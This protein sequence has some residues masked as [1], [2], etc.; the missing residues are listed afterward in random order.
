MA[1]P[2][3]DPGNRAERLR[4]HAEELQ[5]SAS[6]LGDAARALVDEL[7]SAAREQL[8][9]RPFTTLGATAAVGLVLG[10]GLS[11]GVLRRLVGMGGRV[12]VG[13]ALRNVVA[14]GSGKE[15]GG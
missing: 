5:S 8:E 12:A 10:G 7:S 15:G 13:M 14:K 1:G 9:Q 2:Q 11:A 3:A 4:E 6:E